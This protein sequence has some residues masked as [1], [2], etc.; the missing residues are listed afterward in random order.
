MGNIGTHYSNFCL[1]ALFGD[2][3]AAG[4]P[5]SWW[6]GLFYTEPGNEATGTEVDPDV[7]LGYHRIEVPN[8]TTN[9]PNASGAIKRVYP[10]LTLPVPLSTNWGVVPYWAFMDT[11]TVG[12]GLPS[13]WGRLGGVSPPGL[14]M[15][16][17][18]S[19]P[20]LTLIIKLRRTFI[21]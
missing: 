12:F 20:S 14:I 19:I 5:A 9:F 21:S 7:Q 17:S 6:M 8:T 16:S 4:V 2:D 13:A 3:A 1:D 10:E 11:D 18:L 15:G